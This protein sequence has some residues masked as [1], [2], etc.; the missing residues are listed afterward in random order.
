[1]NTAMKPRILSNDSNYSSSSRISRPQQSWLTNPEIFGVNLQP[2]HAYAHYQIGDN[3]MESATQSLNG[4]WH[5]CLSNARDF[6][7]ETTDPFTFNHNDDEYQ[8]I[9][10]PSHWQTS[11]FA[12][13]QYVNTQYPWD[14]HEAPTPPQIPDDNRVGLYRTTFNLEQQFTQVQQAGGRVHLIF[15]GAQTAIYVWLNGNFIGYAEDSF[16]PSEFDVSAY[17]KNADNILCVACYE[18]SSASWLEDQ[19]YWRLH[20]LFRSVELHAKPVAHVAN[21]RIDAD[22]DASQQTGVLSAKLTISQSHNQFHNTSLRVMLQ[23]HSGEATSRI[24][25]T[26]YV[27]CE[28]ASSST[29]SVPSSA[30]RIVHIQSPQLNNIQAWSAESPTL[31][32]FTIDVLNAEGT[33]L[34]RVTQRV[35]FR[36]FEIVNGIMQLNGKRIIFKGVNRHEFNMQRGRAITYRDMLDDILFCKQHNINAIR[37]SHYP[38]QDAWYELC[39][40]FGIY[41]IDET[42]LETHGT[43]ADGNG[44]ITPDTALPASDSSWQAACV[45]RLDA[46]MQRDYN[47]PSV[48]IWSLGNESFGGEVFRAM[49]RHAHYLDPKRPV[50]YE[51]QTMCED[52]RDTTDIESRMYAHADEIES[53]LMN[54]PD[55]PYISCEYMHA[56]GNSVGNL[57]EYIALERYEHYQGG[58]IWD[59]I[60]QNLLQSND[61]V[62][63]LAYGGDFAD[64][65]SDYEFCAN[66][67][68]F[69]DRTPKPHAAQVKQLYANV[70]LT[71]NRHGVSIT[72]NNCFTDT[73]MYL[74]NARI[75]VNGREA[76]SSNY[77]FTVAAGEQQECAI[78]WPLN[79]ISQHQGDDIP[80]IV[81]EVNQ[82]LEQDCPWAK[83]GFTCTY[84]QYVLD[85][86]SAQ[87]TNN[88]QSTTRTDDCD[89]INEH[90]TRYT[91]DSASITIG[92]WNAG[93]RNVS[94]ETLFSYTQGGLISYR[95]DNQEF[96]L[97]K[98]AITTFR[99]LT[100]NDRGCGH[101]FE[102]AMWATAGKYARC[103]RHEIAQKDQTALSATYYYELANTHAT[104]VTIHYTARADGSMH[105]QATYHGQPHQPQLPSLPAFG[106]E[107]KLPLAYQHLRFY[108]LGPEET[109]QDRRAL[110]L[111]IWQSDAFSDFQPYIV[112]QETGN[113]EQVRW[114]EIYDRQGHGMRVKAHR[115]THPFSVSLLPYTSTMIEEAQ[116][117]DELPAPQHM[118]LRLLAE[119]MGVGGDD[120]WMSPVHQQYHLPADQPIELDIDLQ[121]FDVKHPL[122]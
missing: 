59:L 75:L 35:G 31:Y 93:I 110:K 116:H 27:A 91:Q 117:I 21:L 105:I 34:E 12:Q 102:R 77:H 60:D 36:R 107:W 48:L 62:K 14:G 7:P 61:G 53:Y 56:M 20:G 114:A 80:E 2:A 89:E 18:Y 67:L 30:T 118:V 26:Q 43:W 6:N 104:A 45:N 65:P 74:F 32:D 8:P 50:H 9:E 86:N 98:P 121:L 44:D 95:L 94:R 58:F 112:P 81:L 108:G 5:M 109:Y 15:H 88:T 33:V 83:R 55:K 122:R 87:D 64:R 113:H 29:S 63:R 90:N 22:Y 28:H 68:L 54:N 73:S 101:G 24:L 1:M 85:S 23:S 97:Q 16:T 71:P 82:Q 46:M 100:D 92:R 49:A 3:P 69:A 115:R 25:W 119:Q 51:G 79:E 57:D 99:P 40:Q 70:C 96:V 38:N 66:G 10:V 42:N 72:N 76:W 13:P 52:Y 4:M 106:L 111:G 41:L 17:V 84:G 39:D 11:G 47:H 103:T 37:T 19:D 120:S 78:A